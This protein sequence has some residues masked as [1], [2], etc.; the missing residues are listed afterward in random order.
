MPHVFE[1]KVMSASANRKKGAKRL[2]LG[3]LLLESSQ[4]SI[5]MVHVYNSQIMFIRS[6]LRYTAYIPH[7]RNVYYGTRDRNR[8]KNQL[9][10]ASLDKC[11]Q[12]ET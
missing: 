8:F 1:K 11:K 9:F 7:I 3:V 2:A 12:N 10:V 5:Q 6:V 4:H